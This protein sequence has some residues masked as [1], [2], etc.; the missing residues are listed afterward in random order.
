LNFG[1]LEHGLVL[2]LALEFGLKMHWGCLWRWLHPLLPVLMGILTCL[3]STAGACSAGST[4]TNAPTEGHACMRLACS[5]SIVML[6]LRSARIMDGG[7]HGGC[8]SRST[9][10]APVKQV[11]TIQSNCVLL[12][13]RSPCAAAV[14]LLTAP[15]RVCYKQ[16]AALPGWR[17]GGVGNFWGL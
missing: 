6:V 1:D 3:T 14:K 7:V 8:V 17:M 13:S 10:A 9:G 11:H 15:A 12:Q 5:G 16:C 2:R 4:P